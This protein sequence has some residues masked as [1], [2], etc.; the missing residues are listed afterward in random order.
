MPHQPLDRLRSTLCVTACMLLFWSVVTG[1]PEGWTVAFDGN[2]AGSPRYRVST[3]ASELA[4]YMAKV[5]GAEV[6]T[7]PLANAPAERVLV[8][9]DCEHAPP[10]VGKLLEGKRRDAFVIQY[11]FVLDGKT[12]C[13]LVS[14]DIYGYDF[15][16]YY[17]LTKYMDFHWVGPGDLGEVYEQKPDWALPESIDI[18]EN[19]D[20]EMRLWADRGFKM[21]R[22]LLAGS[23]RLG[24]HHAFGGIFA[25][26]KYAK[27]DP[28]IYPLIDGKRMVPETEA[29]APAATQGWQPCVGNPKVEDIAVEHVLETLRRGS[30]RASVSLSVNDGGGNHCTC[31]KCRALDA[32]GAF[33]D[34]LRP[35]LSDRYFRF[36]NR[37]IERVLKENPE[38]YVGVLG[39]GPCST[40]PV[41]TRIHERVI[42][43]AAGGDPTRF[44][45]AGGACSVYHYHLDNAYPTIRHYPRLLAEYLRVVKSAG[46]VGY[47]AQVEHS[48]AAGGP[49]TY[50]LAHLLWDVDHDVD[51]LL[52][53][54][55]ELAFGP[56]AMAAMRAYYDRWE[57]IFS[58]EERPGRFQVINEWNKSHLKKFRTVEWGDLH[59]LDA[60]IVVAQKARLTPRQQ[61]RLDY[62]VTYYQWARADLAQYLMTQDLLNRRWLASRPPTEV[63]DCIERALK[64]TAEFDHLWDNAIGADRTGWL[65]NQKQFKTRKKAKAKRF[66]DSLQ[67]GPIR[68]TV[69]AHLSK[70]IEQALAAISAEQEETEPR[71]AVVAFWE[72]VIETRPALRPFV[73]P[74]IDRLK[75]VERPNLV[76][77][78][79][80]EQGQAGG[81]KP[82]QPP[83]LPGWWFYDRVGMVVGSKSRYEWGTR[84]SRDGTK[85]IGCGPGKYPGLRGYL[86]LEPGRYRFSFWYKTEGRETGLGVNLL[87]LIET[88][89]IATLKTVAAVR[90]QSSHNE[91]YIKFLINR[92]PPT[93][94]EWANI[95]TIFESKDAASFCVMLEPFGMPEDAWVWFDDVEIRKLW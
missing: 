36:Y 91:E 8:L 47:Y 9:T 23:N 44:A 68:T 83:T 40:P 19:P 35:N 56:Y 43:F 26:R 31:D 87:K 50:V 6:K 15:P 63:L 55:L 22:P 59:F 65:L 53:E 39:Y 85:C 12:V 78:G 94:G 73:Q 70:G 48:W 5:L 77:N 18:L 71:E 42:V 29:G 66:Y 2:V 3:A 34:P 60:A 7:C 21:A 64:L 25:P 72:S 67:V 93:G 58:R 17:F 89:D 51:A 92:Y 27:T 57:E 86:K 54:Y 90:K 41:A 61:K 16:G 11:P 37:V 84:A 80:F 32:E 45:A 24:F 30:Q 95:S 38:A 1:E 20:F 75:G 69:E 28:D 14:H 74:E 62:F 79:S 4:A 10:E 82:G 88:V 76:A 81:A 33:K 13:L 49:K 46:G 52:D